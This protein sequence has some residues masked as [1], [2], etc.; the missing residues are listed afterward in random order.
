MNYLLFF[1]LCAL[2]SIVSIYAQEESATTTTTTSTEG[3]SASSVVLYVC[4]ASDSTFLGSYTAGSEKMDGVFVY[5]N[6]QDRSF[7]RSRGFWYLGNLGP[8]PP[9]THYR[10]VEAE[11]CNYNGEVPPT[12]EEGAWKGSKRFNDGGAPRITNQP[13]ASAGFDEL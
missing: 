10:C 7:F 11:G 2:L 6:E 13:C 1:Y 4:E 3:D 5:T 12:S 9:E 8:W